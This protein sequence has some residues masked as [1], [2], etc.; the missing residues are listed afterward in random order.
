MLQMNLEPKDTM[1]ERLEVVA[2]ELIQSLPLHV[3]FLAE[4]YMTSFLALG[5]DIDDEKV[6][7]ALDKVKDVIRYIEEG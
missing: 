4:S 2:G 6:T 5:T 7:E 3:R 1:K